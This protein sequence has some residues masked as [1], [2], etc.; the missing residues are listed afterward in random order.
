MLRKA[1]TSF[2]E[3]M[4]I[5][6]QITPK[7]VRAKRGV[8]DDDDDDTTDDGVSSAWLLRELSC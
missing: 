2:H 3:L 6:H 8:I 4:V 1:V 5:Q 7:K